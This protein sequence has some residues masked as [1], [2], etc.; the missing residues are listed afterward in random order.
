[1]GLYAVLPTTK[2]KK[3][4]YQ[5]PKQSSIPKSTLTLK[6]KHDTI[7]VLVFSILLF[8]DTEVLRIS[9]EKLGLK[10]VINKVD[11][12]EPCP[13]VR[14]ENLQELI[15]LGNDQSASCRR[16]L[17]YRGRSKVHSIVGCSIIWN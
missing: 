17:V 14:D 6:L 4:L 7:L 9:A 12:L 13:G 15:L 2:C 11:S 5:S 1:M 16:E 3:T 8:S 10:T